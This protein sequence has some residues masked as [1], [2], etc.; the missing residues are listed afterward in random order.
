MDPGRR[1]E[2]VVGN[3]GR[4]AVLLFWSASCLGAESAIYA[5]GESDGSLSISN[6]PT[7]RRYSVLVGSD[8]PMRK[9]PSRGAFRDPAGSARSSQYGDIVERAANR[10]GLESA[11]LHAVIAVESGYDPKARSPKGAGGLMQLMPGTARRYGVADAFDP[12]QNVDGGARY[13]RDL[14]QQFDSDLSLVLAAYNAGENAV[15]RNQNRIPRIRETLNYVPK[16]L[17]HYRKYQGSAPAD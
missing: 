11:L 4:A 12:V 15:T 16:V 9:L 6:V 2:I 5:Y 3:F 8:D 13:L 10:Y 14:L 7:D 17:A 1:L